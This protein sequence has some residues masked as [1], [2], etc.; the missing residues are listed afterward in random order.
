MSAQN[1][2]FPSLLALQ[3]Q[4]DRL[5]DAL[6]T[7]Q[8]TDGFWDEVTAFIQRAQTTGAILDIA[9]ERRAAQ[10]ILD[11]W[12]NALY[13]EDRPAPGARLAEF[14]INLA[15]DL[16]DQPCPYRGWRL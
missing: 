9:N 6:D 5:L 15:P 14:D 11:Y 12:D 7:G 3:E 2:R 4:N 10:S 13:R 8:S 16:K 1:E